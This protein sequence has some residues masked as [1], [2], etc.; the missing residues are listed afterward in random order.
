MSNEQQENKEFSE[1]IA[2]QTFDQQNGEAENGAGGDD[3]ATEN[4]AGQEN[5]EDRLIHSFVNF[6]T[7]Q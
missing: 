7:S 4:G 5:Q 1:D 6:C 2:E 3:A